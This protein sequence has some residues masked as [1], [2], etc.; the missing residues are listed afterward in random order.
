MSAP[1]NEV[2]S[3]NIGCDVNVVNMVESKSPESTR[4]RRDSYHHG[5]L[6]RALTHAALSLVAERGPKGFTLTEAARRAGVSAAAPYRHFADKADLL[7][8]VAE[9]GFVELH[10]ALTATVDVASDPAARLISIG[11]SYVRWA[12]DHPDHYRVMFG[13][14]NDKAQHPSLAAAAGRAFSDLLDV[15]TL[16][17]A[18][19]I[20]RGV[21]PHQLAGPLWSLVHGIASLAIDGELRN[22][23]IDQDPEDMVAEAVGVFF[24]R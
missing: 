11:R 22:V 10:T 9:Q 14:G 18:A 5:D 21:E 7:A 8:A 3:F 1:F 24:T 17:Q 16:C 12:I 2:N 19:G 20:L 4:T 13:A 23:G 15:I 6:K